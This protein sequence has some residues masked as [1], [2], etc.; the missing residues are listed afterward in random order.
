MALLSI[1]NKT[2]I[3]L[4]LLGAVLFL[5]PTFMGQSTALSATQGELQAKLLQLL[6]EL[7]RLKTQVNQAKQTVQNSE[8]AQI[9]RNL[10]VGSRGEDVRVLQ[11]ILNANFAT[12]VSASGP[13]SSGNETDYFGNLTKDAVK[14][15]QQVYFSNIL[16]PI[17]LL[18]GTGFVGPSTRL[19]LNEIS[20]TGDFST[21]L[22]N[23]PIITA[24]SPKSTTNGR[25]ITIF[26]RGFTPTGNNIT[27]GPDLYENIPS[28]DGKTLQVQ[29]N[30]TFF[31]DLFTV[32]RENAFTTANVIGSSNSISS[33]IRQLFTDSATDPNFVFYNE[34]TQ[35]ERNFIKLR[36]GLLTDE[37][38]S[39]MTPEERAITEEFL[40]SADT[41]ERAFYTGGGNNGVVPHPVIIRNGNGES[42]VAEFYLQLFDEP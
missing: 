10:T 23:I 36:T 30:S 22:V 20:A 2:F 34:L 7:E 39:L 12:A 8:G 38:I 41:R 31:V 15:F 42:S 37:L 6:A 19:K 13:G 9:E 11:K 5:G 21:N 14:R 32:N 25:N 24:V 29:V 28:S 16:L 27:V 3:S 1:R 33:K 40:A 4:F 26:G 17:G 18:K 35:E